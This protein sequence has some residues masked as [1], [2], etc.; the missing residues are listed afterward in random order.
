MGGGGGVNPMGTQCLYGV[1]GGQVRENL[2]MDIGWGVRPIF[3]RVLEAPN[4]IVVSP[5][6]SGKVKEFG[7]A[8]SEQGPFDSGFDSPE[9]F[10]QF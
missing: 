5:T 6:N 1:K 8:V 4:F 2:I 3:S 10:F 7:V 9:F